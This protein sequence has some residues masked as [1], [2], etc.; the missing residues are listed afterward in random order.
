MD[1]VYSEDGYSYWKLIPITTCDFHQYSV[2]YQGS[3]TKIQG[4]NSIDSVIIYS[5]TTQDITF[6]L[7][8]TKEQP[9][10]GYTLFQT[11]QPKIIYI[12]NN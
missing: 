9:L 11:E 12:K 2:L 10:C 6:A 7:T 8:K 3:A 1:S 5:L 4:D